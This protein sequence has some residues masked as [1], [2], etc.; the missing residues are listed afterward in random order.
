MEKRLSRS[1]YLFTLVFIFMLVAVVAAFFYGTRVGKE[2][3][4]AKYEHVLMKQQALSQEQ[5][6]YHQQY[7]V[8]FYHTIYLPYR[9]FQNKWFDFIEALELQSKSVDTASALKQLSRIAIDQYEEAAALSMPESSPLLQEAQRN[10]LKSLKLFSDAAAKFARQASK[11]PDLSQAIKDDAYFQEAKNFALLAQHNYYSSIVK[12]HESLGAPLDGSEFAELD[13]LN[14][15]EWGRLNFNLKNVVIA[16]LLLNGQYY[17]PY[18]VHDIT[19]RIDELAASGQAVKM[20]LDDIG[21]IVEMLIHTGAVRQNDF[22]KSKNKYYE[23]ETMPQL[24]FFFQ[25]N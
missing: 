9:E 23:N 13:S 3:T 16:R 10:Y 12:W 19:I 21:Q 15:K 25:Q 6:A 14:V 7:L 11:S 2:Q 20:K 1:D 18:H 8:S 22:I 5:T 17:E 24:P 4:V